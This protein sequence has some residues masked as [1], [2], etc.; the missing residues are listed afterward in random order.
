MIRNPRALRLS[1]I[2]ALAALILLT[3]LV[4]APLATA[5]AAAGDL[6]PTFG[7]G[8]RVAVT[9]DDHPSGGY[10]IAQQPD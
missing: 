5:W 4:L 9:F 8:G 2:P 6:D 7:Q 3:A 1:S 10:A